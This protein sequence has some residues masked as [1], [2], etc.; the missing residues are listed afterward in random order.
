MKN[1]CLAALFVAGSILLMPAHGNA[2]C[3]PLDDCGQIPC[4]FG[5]TIL[6]NTTWNT[7]GYTASSGTTFCSG[8]QNDLWFPFLPDSTGKVKIT[9]SPSNCTNGDGV[10]VA[11]Y[12]SC[13]EDPIAC[14]GGNQGGGDTPLVLN[15]NVVP[16]QIHFLMVDGYGG[17]ICDIQMQVSGILDVG[18]ISL[19]TGQVWEDTNF[20]C[21]LDSMDLPVPEAPIAVS[22]L[23]SAIVPAD[24]LGKFTFAF[25]AFGSQG[26]DLALEVWESHLWSPCTDT[27]HIVPSVGP[28]TTHVNFLLQPLD[29]CTELRVDIGLQSFFRPCQ[30]VT[31]PVKYSNRGTR[32][33]ENAVLDIVFP[34]SSISIQN[35]TMP[36][37]SLGDTL[38]FYLGKVRPFEIGNFKVLGRINCDGSLT[39]HTLCFS[40]HAYPDTACH[41]NPNWS[42]AH[43]AVSAVCEGDSL[44]RFAIRNTGTGSM[45]GQL[46]Y[47]VISNAGIVETGMFQLNAGQDTTLAFAADGSTWRIEAEQEPLHPGMS[48][49]SASLEGC[50]GLTP[51]YV[52]AF[53]QDDADL[54]RDVECRMVVAS[55]D[56]NIKVASPAGVGDNRVIQPNTPLEYTI[57]FQ[58]T[59]NDTAFLVRLVDVLPYVLDPATFRP[60]TSSHPCTW[61]LLSG[62]TLEIIFDPIVL[63]DSTTNEPASH[64]WFE[65]SIAQRPNLPNGTILRNSAAI[66]FDYNDPVITDP[67]LH[68]IG[69]LTVHVDDLPENLEPGWRVLGNPLQDRCVFEATKAVSGPGRFE[70]FDLQG[71]LLRTEIFDGNQFVFHRQG[72]APGVYLFRIVSTQRATFSGKLVIP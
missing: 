22:G 50:G 45:S 52:N 25:P 1:P 69:Q 62:D 55:Y 28:D 42:G 18:D 7:A 41:I 14:N 34:V 57:H 43:V 38:R 11:V 47:R 40:A 53:P 64:G 71:R 20:D 10:Q 36:F 3:V 68:T 19:V 60:G 72:Q 61:R 4:L 27:V 2:Q 35:A 5:P 46:P 65:F 39:G 44:V 30:F 58:N 9:I 33:V 8:I 37:D 21:Q 31:I 56:P 16:G 26:F 66:Y 51:G 54:F 32:A 29:L 59:G 49:P 70:L 24:S 63:P 15:A 48:K 17:D 12:K 23:Y 13:T 67:A 6:N